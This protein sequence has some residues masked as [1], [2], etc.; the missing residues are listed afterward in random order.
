LENKVRRTHDPDSPDP[1]WLP[2]YPLDYLLPRFHIWVESNFQV[3]PNAGGMDDQP[4]ALMDDFFMLRR[5]LHIRRESLKRQ[6]DF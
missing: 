4:D 6:V 1:Q 2:H 3:Y 5:K